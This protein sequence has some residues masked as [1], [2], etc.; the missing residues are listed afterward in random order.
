MSKKKADNKNSTPEF[1]LLPLFEESTKY[2]YD[3]YSETAFVW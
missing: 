3:L 2:A 1:F